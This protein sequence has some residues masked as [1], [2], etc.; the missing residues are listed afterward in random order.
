MAQ[1]KGLIFESY[2]NSGPTQLPDGSRITSNIASELPETN[3]IQHQNLNLDENLDDSLEYEE[4]N[5]EVSNAGEM[6]LDFVRNGK[7]RSKSSS[8]EGGGQNEVFEEL[9]Q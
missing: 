3:P 5:M 4:E 7:Q 6:A 1:S 9:K 8:E 2:L